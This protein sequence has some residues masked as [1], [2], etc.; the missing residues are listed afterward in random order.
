[1]RQLRILLQGIALC[2]LAGMCFGSASASTPH[3]LRPNDLSPLDLKKWV[4]EDSSDKARV[5]LCDGVMDIVSPDGLTLW[6]DQRLDGD[7]EIS[8][9]I[10]VVMEGGKYDRLSD[11]NCF[12]GA[13]DPKHPDDIYARAKWRH[14]VFRNY[15]TLDLF[16]V[17]HGGND[18]G[19][20]RFRRYMGLNHD[21][22]VEQNKPVIGEYTDEDH[23]LKANHWYEIV[24]NVRDGRTSYSCDGEVF[25]ERE[26][27]REQTDGYFA[28]RLWINHV[29]VRDFKI[30]RGPAQ[31]AYQNFRRYSR[32]GLAV[33]DAGK[34]EAL[35]RLRADFHRMA[36]DYEADPEKDRAAA[37][38]YLSKLDE[39]GRFTDMNALEREFDREN[40]WTMGYKNTTDDAV[41]LFLGKA[42]G[43]IYNIARVMHDESLPDRV[44]RAI[45]HYGRREVERSNFIPRFHASC[46]ALP[47]AAS[48]IYFSLLDRMD[49]AER[50]EAGPLWKDA[51]DMLKVIGMEAYTQPMRR[52]ST[53]RNVVSIE[54][55]RNHVWWV[56]GNALAYRPL[57]NVALMYRSIPM[58]DLLA[59]ICPRS[60][61]S[62]SQHTLGDAFWTE[63]F[64][65]DGAGWG[66][67]KQCLIWGYPIDG[68]FHALNMLSMLKGTPWAQ[69]LDRENVDALMNFFRGGNWYYYKGYTL[70]GLDRN[71]YAYRNQTREIPYAAMLE[72]VLATWPTSF[73]EEELGEL[74]QL[75]QEVKA[76]RIN[77]GNRP[78][79][80][81]SG[82]RWFFNQDD[83][84]KK[85][86]SY[87]L[88]IN[89]AGNRVDGLESAAFADNY[90]FYPTDGAT[91]FQ[92]E[93]DEYFRVMGG[94][95]VCFMPGVTAREGMERLRPVTNW[96]G[97]CSKHNFAAGATRGGENAVAGFHFEKVHGGDKEEQHGSKEGHDLYED[98][99][100]LYGFEAHKGYFILGDYFV[101][102]GAGVTNH[103]PEQE[104]H[105]IT[106]L[107]QTA[108]KGDVTVSGKGRPEGDG[109]EFVLTS[110]KLTW[111]NQCGGFSYA[112]LPQYG[113]TL[114]VKCENRTA[115]WGKYNVTNLRR[116]DLPDEL[117]TLR[118]WI[119]H[120]QAPTDD[121]YG[122]VVYMGD[123]KPAKKLPFEVL[124]NDS[125]V[126]ALRSTRGDVVE[127][128]FYDAEER[129]E[130]KDLSIG[131]SAPCALLVEPGRVTVTDAEM[132]PELKTITVEVNGRR[133]EVEMPSGKWCGKP[134]TTSL[135]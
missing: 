72:K 87:H 115:D 55:F 135:E 98:N 117:P 12:W 11:M 59:E 124:R 133:L 25:F 42:Y 3:D 45:L 28:I 41:G 75:E 105:I 70:P 104:G 116:E 6:Y 78:E 80:L 5:E 89:M 63:G 126:Q 53:D 110:P 13:R 68:T 83:L 130:A 29:Q 1:M 65:A 93:G 46:F 38:K 95:D 51:A 66:H 22:G 76:R 36:L 107:D 24:I 20:T 27:T 32:E 64:T 71:S 102:L 56:G 99:P 47:R 127:A 101:A 52:D 16:Y 88:S 18:N 57:L 125:R 48:N 10:K 132:N 58:L 120:G 37:E 77:M 123:G 92:R 23:L 62:T 121:C 74:R 85:N 122:Y 113:Q 39:R 108:W 67:G 34:R 15:N 9:R 35:T 119:D 43:R 128:V 7:Y 21:K 114:H 81:Y 60:I 129:L 112:L 131:V 4:V 79:G 94:W 26:A 30:L 96:R 111:V 61:S 109:R 69:Q 49:R 50:G 17:G 73:S 103:R 100:L 40:T 90:N 118:L 82:S 33:D 31:M 44:L 134:A 106:T 2:L 84:I 86:D 14:G 8:Y 54:R 97:Y 91:L 19:T